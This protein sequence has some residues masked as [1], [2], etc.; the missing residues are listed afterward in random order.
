MNRS[1]GKRVIRLFTLVLV[2]WSAV[3]TA[4]EWPKQRPITIVAAFGPGVVDTLARL[5]GQKLGESV[6]QAVVVENRPGAGGNIGAQRVQRSAP[7]GYTL[8]MTSVAYAINPSLY[9]NAGYEPFKDFTP[10][11][12]VAVVPNLISVHPSVPA[13]NLEELIKLARQQPLA[14]ASPGIGTS[15]H[16]SMERIKTIAKV[17][18]THVPYQPGQA[19]TALL[20]GQAPVLSIAVTLPLPHIKAGK[21]RPLAVTSLRRSP[22]LPEVPTVDEQGMKGF[23]D[24]NWFGLFSPARTPDEVLNRLNTEVNRI[25]ELPDVKEKFGQLGLEPRRNTLAEFAA[26]VREEVPKWAKAVKDSGAK[27][28]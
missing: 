7:D 1:M 15:P 6:G 17:D 24:L 19:V 9:P 8:L 27:V 14:Y 23:D 11:I 2:G 16:L 10:V 12:L 28:D 13:N 25:L 3:A 22:A 21:I 5:V 4:Q 18:I 20:G 26:F